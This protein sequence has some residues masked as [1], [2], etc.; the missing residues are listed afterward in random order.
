MSRQRVAVAGA[1]GQMGRTLCKALAE[2]DR[3]ELVAAIDPSAR[4]RRVADLAGIESEVVVSGD[5]GAAL[6]A[7]AEAVVDFTVAEAASANL[8]FCAANG[9]H[10]VC[11]TTGLRAEALA[12][13]EAAFAPAAAP[14]AVICANFAISAVVMMRLA[15]VAAAYFDSAEIIELHHDAKRD[16]PSGTAMETARRIA[17]AR[18]ASGRGDFGADPTERVVLEGARGGRG[19]AN[20]ALHSVRLRGLV[21]HE[22]VL[23]G[24]LGQSLT[25][26]QDSYDR[27]SFMPGVLLALAKVATTPGLTIGLDALL[28]G[29]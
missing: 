6:A 1:A 21:A 8:L 13:I 26:R 7:G 27:T 15:E 17:A 24:A 18:Q 10:A 14:N 25:I 29:L 11:G 28:E 16:A 3:V 2:D 23:F 4:G 20:I 22:E 12:E 19:P 5:L 9:L